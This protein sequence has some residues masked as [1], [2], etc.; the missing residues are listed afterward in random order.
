MVPFNAMLNLS[1]HRYCISAAQNPALLHQ[2]PT[3][4]ADVHSGSA[5]EDLSVDVG[6][7]SVAPCVQRK[8]FSELAIETSR[9]LHEMAVAI[10]LQGPSP[11]LMDVMRAGLP[12][13]VGGYTHGTRMH[14]RESVR[15]V[16]LYSR[17]VLGKGIL[18]ERI[19]VTR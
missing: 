13:L 15:F 8:N 12:L 14:T 9:K 2:T 16:T 19:L 10:A 11:E 1:L 18:E 6:S 4:V 3:F 5:F 7:F 17:P